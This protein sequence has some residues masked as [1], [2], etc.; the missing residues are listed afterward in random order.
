MSVVRRPLV[1]RVL[2][3]AVV[4][5]GIAF[6]ATT[7]PGL[8]SLRPPGF[9]PPVDGWL[10]GTAYTL[11]AAL[12]LARPLLVERDRVLWGLVAAAVTARSLA[13]LL[14]FTV[15]RT[16]QPP[17]Y[18]SVSDGFWIASALALVG[19]L[20]W[21]VRHGTAPALSR[22]LALDGLLAALVAAG[23]GV[24]AVQ[25]VLA[26]SVAEGTPAS[27]VTVN[28][29][30]PLLDVVTLVLVAGLVAS[31]S[32][33]ERPDVV[34]LVGIVVSAAVDVLYLLML[35][36]GAWRPGT[37][38]SALALL[39]TTLVC[40]APW[41]A[42]SQL[43]PRPPAPGADTPGSTTRSITTPSVVWTAA[44]ALVGLVALVVIEVVLDSSVAALVLLTSG[45]VVALVRGLLTLREDQQ[46]ADELLG[47]S[48]EERERF[49]ALVQAS[50]DFVAIADLD[51]SLLYLNPAGRA[52]VGLAPDADVVGIDYE[53]LRPPEVL[54]RT[55]E[56]GMPTLRRQ[57][58]VEDT[59]LL[60]H[61][62]GGDPVPVVSHSFVMR[63]PR[64]GRAIALGSIQRDVSAANAA[65]AAL[66][67]LAHERQELLGRLVQAQDDERARIAADVHD[68]SVQ[69]LAAVQ[70][71]LGLLERQLEELLDDEQL[72]A[73]RTV[74]E[75]VAEATARLRHLLFDLESPARRTD[76]VSALE[77]AASYVLD[78]VGVSWT[79]VGEPP[80]DLPEATRVTAYR[81][82]KEALGNVRRHAGAHHVR[83]EVARDPTGTTLCVLDDGRGIAPEEDL[84]RPGHLGLASMRDRA[85]VAGGQLVVGRGPDGGTRVRLWLPVGAAGA[86]ATTPG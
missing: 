7:L 69:A 47:S 78:E 64:T 77:E 86:E 80:G 63:S 44:L 61:L 58:H 56:Y 81:V 16:Q 48:A 76:L 10:Q 34:L 3:S 18:P 6:T 83:I 57:G 39:G 24:A 46:E 55:R 45:V 66:E 60:A 22:L 51:G 27:A 74:Q 40:L 17:P 84:A 13:F 43:G 73:L 2:V 67:Q 72:T 65:A 28:L 62:G 25:P 12:A 53:V 49:A 35:V 26:A 5:V 41:S 54:Q 79:I 23:I 20:L 75:T 32:R 59:T 14:F 52:M 68:D 42:S 36:Q 29:A 19:A 1:V 33:A 82:A 50:T 9:W 8:S 15:V 21:R 37:P 30:Y 38:V 11:L 4:V 70:L 31:G 85:T 71:R